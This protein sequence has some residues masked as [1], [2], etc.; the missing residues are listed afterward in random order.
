MKYVLFL[1][2]I[3]FSNQAV[4]LNCSKQPTCEELNY[5]KEENPKCA[6]NGYIFC[7]Y[8]QTYKK[9]VQY[10]CESLG[11][12][13][14]DKNPWCEEIIYCPQDESYSL[15]KVHQIQCEI[16]DVF[17]A[18]RTCG[19]VADWSEKSGKIPVGVVYYLTDNGRH[20][21]VIN[22]HDLGRSINDKFDPTDPY[23]D[24]QT[25]QWGMVYKDIPQLKNW[26]CEEYKIAAE[27]EDR[28]N[29]FWAAGQKYTAIIAD[30]QKNDLQYPA[31]AAKA[32]Y[33]PEVS[34]N[35]SIVG[36][37]KW[38]LP[39]LGELM[40]LYGYNYQGLGTECQGGSGKIGANLKV[41]NATLNTL[42]NKGVNAEVVKK[43]Y[44]WSSSEF[45]SM[46]AW[47]LILSGGGERYYHGKEKKVRVRPSLQF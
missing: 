5:S 4:A 9:C 24:N 37:G 35:D 41:V 22:L 46:H 36:Q 27:T 2:A 25:F 13:K 45:S 8:D 28:A 31:P 11:F 32:F 30:Y 12:T 38:Y 26:S 3:L 10:S 29:D 14:S 17:Y 33:P 1:I 19:K 42:M 40:D 23:S 43:D 18:D 21:K 39:T 16:G 15:C 7:P 47:I 6:D 44:Y 34:A 20:G